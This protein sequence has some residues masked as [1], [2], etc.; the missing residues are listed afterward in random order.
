[1]APPAE[2]PAAGAPAPGV[3]AAGA[4]AAE[5]PADA[6]R[7][8]ATPPP[9]DSAALPPHAPAPSTANPS[10]QNPF[11]RG[12]TIT[13]ISKARATGADQRM[14]GLL[15]EVCRFGVPSSGVDAWLASRESA[16]LAAQ[17]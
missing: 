7:F 14:R 4:P 6:P 17:E 15:A 10:Q 12:R 1:M 2:L 16:A 8:P 5:A 13:P 3:P 9:K 11:R